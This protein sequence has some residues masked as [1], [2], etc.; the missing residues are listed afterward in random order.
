MLDATLK[1]S[2]LLML[3]ALDDKNG[4][5]HW[6]ASPYLD[7]A[8]AGGILAE[9]AARGAITLDAEKVVKADKSFQH[10]TLESSLHEHAF[11]LIA[12]S[13]KAPRTI[14][15]WVATLSTMEDLAHRQTKELV[16][17]GILEEHEESFLFLFHRQRY[18]MRDAT[19][20]KQIIDKIRRAL[21][22]R[23]DVEPRLAVLITLANGAH[24][25]KGPISEGE[26]DRSQDR[27]KK[28]AS[29]QVIGQAACNHIKDAEQALYVASSIPFMGVPQ[30]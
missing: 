20:E 19:P 13:D 28:I 26:L 22:D 10:S 25:L 2:E 21:R 3:L 7:Y 17:L 24:L 4:T 27:L 11:I 8:L 15:E 1:V 5:V 12:Q 6:Q 18:P 30:L 23:G 9:L 14:S 29:G 16:D